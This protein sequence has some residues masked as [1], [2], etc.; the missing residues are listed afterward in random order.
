MTCWILKYYLG[1]CFSHL[2]RFGWCCK[3]ILNSI[4]QSSWNFALVPGTLLPWWEK[5]IQNW[6]HYYIRDHFVYAPSQWEMTL[7]CNVISHW[8]G[9][10]TKWSLYIHTNV[11]IMSHWNLSLGMIHGFLVF[12]SLR[13]GDAY[14]HQCTRPSLVQ[15]MAC[16]LFGVNPL[17]EPMP[18][19]R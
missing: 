4:V 17:S 13:P 8:L 15:I 12:N 2:F 11:N 1:F 9:A 3:L 18:S 7:H 5:K 19:Y 14:M 16:H 6:L 10:Y